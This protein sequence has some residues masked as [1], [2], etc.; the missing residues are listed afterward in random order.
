ME[1]I[2]IKYVKKCSKM[3]KNVLVL[4]FINKKKFYGLQFFQSKNKNKE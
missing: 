2:T 1:K 3:Q 4:N